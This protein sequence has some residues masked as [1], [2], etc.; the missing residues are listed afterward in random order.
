MHEKGKSFKGEPSPGADIL[1]GGQGL[2]QSGGTI[3]EPDLEQN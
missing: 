1:E 2:N 3:V